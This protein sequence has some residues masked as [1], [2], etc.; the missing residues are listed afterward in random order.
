MIEGE[1]AADFHRAM[2]ERGLVVP[3]GGALA[4]GKLHRCDVDGPRG[5]GDGSY[6]LYGDG[7][8]AGGLQNWRDGEGW[9]S[10]RFDTDRRLTPA[11]DRAFRDRQAAMR[12]QR[13][14]EAARRNAEATALAVAIWRE[15]RAPDGHPYLA[16]KGI[17]PSGA[18]QMD[19]SRA[20]ELG[21]WLE[22]DGPLLIVPVLGHDRSLRGLQFIDPEGNKRFLLGTRKGGGCFLVGELPANVL[23]IAE[24]F[25]TAA[26]VHAATGWPVAVAFDAGNLRAVAAALRGR[27]PTTR[28][29]IAGD[30]DSNGMGQRAAAEAANAVGGSVAIPAAEGQDWND[31]TK[32]EGIEAVRTE[33]LA[34]LAAPP[35]SGIEIVRADAIQVEPVAWLWRGWLARGKLHLIAGAPGTGKTTIALALAA[36][37]SRCGTFP[38]GS[39]SE[40]GATLIWSGEDDAADSLV[41]R[42]LANGGDSSRLHVVGGRKEEGRTVPFNPSRDMPALTAEAARL[43]DLRLIVL[44]PILS[45]VEGDAHKAADTR[46]GLQPVVDMA[47]A[48]DAAVL[49]IT[50]FGK[51]TAGR[52]TAERVIASQAF[53]AVARIVMATAKPAEDG[54]ARRLVRSKS[55]IGPDDGGFEYELAQVLLAQHP[56]IF[57]QR[58]EFGEQ[59]EGTAREL[60][61]EIEGEPGESGAP[62]RDA[63]AEWLRRA[64][65]NGPVL[66]KEIGTRAEADGIKPKTLRNARNAIGVTVEKDGMRGGWVWSLGPKMPS[67]HEDAPL[68]KEGIFGDRGHLRAMGDDMEEF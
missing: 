52:D 37:I 5:R 42:F 46:R 59:L 39:P 57:G 31:R 53:V 19:A 68:R 8:P 50:H 67:N 32:T 45:V 38:D 12:R 35:S 10:W 18:R 17:E 62:A 48:L 4:D 60:L 44:D 28:I 56:G 65:A 25:A 30:N 41:P 54:Q 27:A 16:R 11:E 33:L 1:A 15:S 55:N 49:G 64:L 36:V 58:V 34:A 7:V 26:S 3:P 6:V 66:A 14:A 43:P 20:R 29:V 13:E 2:R 61:A 21:A 24:G 63:A 47:A 40:P 22:L 9:Q 23:A 51:S